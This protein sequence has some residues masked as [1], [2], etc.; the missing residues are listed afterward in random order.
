MLWADAVCINQK[1]N[2]EKGHQ[3]AMMNEIYKRTGQVLIWLDA[4]DQETV[5]SIRGYQILADEP[6]TSTISMKRADPQV[7]A[8][9]NRSPSA[10]IEESHVDEN[11]RKI[12]KLFLTG[13]SWNPYCLFCLG[14]TMLLMWP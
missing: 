14:A 2:I 6:K 10:E 8:W 12:M 13:Q 5:Y 9:I 11:S 3:V 7:A 4:G 1:D